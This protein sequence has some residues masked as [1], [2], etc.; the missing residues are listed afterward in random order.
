MAVSTNWG[1]GVLVVG[2]LKMTA[3]ALLSALEVW[4]TY[5]LP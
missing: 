4:D 2:V 3:L 1:G 5:H